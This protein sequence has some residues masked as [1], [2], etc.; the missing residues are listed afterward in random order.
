VGEFVHTI[1][2]AHIY[3]NHI[4]QVET[5]LAREPKELP[6]LELKKGKSLFEMELDDMKLSGYDPHPAIKAPVAV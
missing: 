5:Q 2:D 4:E 6:T 1:G 3:T